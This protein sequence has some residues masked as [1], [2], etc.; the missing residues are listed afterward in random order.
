MQRG[1][2]RF[3]TTVPYELKD[4]DFVSYIEELHQIALHKH[5]GGQSL[6]ESFSGAYD[7]PQASFA[8]IR[9]QHARTMHALHETAQQQAQKRAQPRQQSQAQPSSSALQQRTNNRAQANFNNLRTPTQQAS[10][11]VAKQA[12]MQGAKQT[13]QQTA[14]Q[15]VPRATPSFNQTA[16]AVLNEQERRKLE[17]KFQELFNLQG[18]ALMFGTFTFTLLWG[19]DLYFP[20]NLIV[21]AVFALAVIGFIYATAQRIRINRMLNPSP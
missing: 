9:A 4:G 2:A 6:P 1:L 10:K 18:A 17:K 12:A 16:Q 15:A 20:G 3:S 14:K 8:Q 21:G 19:L 13:A 5:L 7:S 11:Q